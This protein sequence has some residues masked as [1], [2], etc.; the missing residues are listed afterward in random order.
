MVD[1]IFNKHSFSFLRKI[2]SL[3]LLFMLLVPISS[4]YPKP[5]KSSKATYRIVQ[6]AFSGDENL[7]FIKE[8]SQ[9]NR[10]RYEII[11]GKIAPF[12]GKRKKN[13][14]KTDFILTDTMTFPVEKPPLSLAF[15]HKPGWIFLKD[16]T[17]ILRLDINTGITISFAMHVPCT[18]SETYMMA[19][20][21][22]LL[23]ISCNS[24]MKENSR[25]KAFRQLFLMS[26]DDGSVLFDTHDV[27]ADLGFR[28]DSQRLFYPV[29]KTTHSRED[30]LIMSFD[31]P[32]KISSPSDKTKDDL[33]DFI[34]TNEWKSQNHKYIAKDDGSGSPFIEIYLP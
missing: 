1:N 27:P 34:I 32:G 24:D 21:E 6:L 11:T 28:L 9:N 10:E 14:P 25:G 12:E 3:F 29:I 13:D 26:A 22:S 7:C 16:G 8:I 33:K 23:L 19:T 4:I 5:Q 30:T 17:T 31:A 15:C 20:P 18:T 2:L